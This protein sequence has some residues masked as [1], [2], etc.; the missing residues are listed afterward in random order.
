MFD[1]E[2][3]IAKKYP[4]HRLDCLKFQNPGFN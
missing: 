2:Y 4:N 1:R 3:C